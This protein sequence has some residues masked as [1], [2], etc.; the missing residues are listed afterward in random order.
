M[1]AKTGSPPRDAAG[2]LCAGTSWRGDSI[3]LER[4]PKGS[5]T[6]APFGTRR[7]V[8]SSPVIRHHGVN[9]FARVVPPGIFE[10]GCA[11]VQVEYLAGFFSVLNLCKGKHFSRLAIVE[12]PCEAIRMFIQIDGLYPHLHIAAVRPQ[13]IA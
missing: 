9:I 3:S 4:A 11:M 5:E 12:I 1:P 10:R 13:T 2:C 8:V 6:S 7:R